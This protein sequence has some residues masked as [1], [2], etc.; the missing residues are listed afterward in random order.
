MGLDLGNSHY[1]KRKGPNVDLNIVGVIS[2]GS[3]LFGESPLEV[4]GGKPL[5]NDSRFGKVVGRKEV[6]GVGSI[7]RSH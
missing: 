7:L 4:Q 3:S 2:V 5:S 6:G 1:H